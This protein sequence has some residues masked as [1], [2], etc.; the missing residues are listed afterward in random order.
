[1]W[2]WWRWIKLCIGIIYISPL[3]NLCMYTTYD[4]CTVW[5]MHDTQF[6]YAFSKILLFPIQFKR[7][8]LWEHQ[9]RTQSHWEG[10]LW[11]FFWEQRENFEMPPGK[12]TWRAG[13][14]NNVRQA[15]VCRLERSWRQTWRPVQEATRKVEKNIVLPKHLFNHAGR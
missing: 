8:I 14:Q 3:Y 12:L 7:H 2:F 15:G 13:C 1:L 6:W 5:F 4:L 9:S 10:T 11:K